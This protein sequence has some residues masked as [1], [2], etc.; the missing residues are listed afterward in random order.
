VID[1]LAHRRG[2]GT[3]ATVD[4]AAAD[5][6]AA[7]D[8]NHLWHPFT[9]MQ[10][11]CAADHE[12]LIIER[13]EDVWLWDQNG[14][15][16]ID[17]NSSIW[18]NIHGHSH[19]KLLAA[20][21]EQ[22]EKIAHSSFLGLT[23]EP[24]IRLAAGLAEKSPGGAL[25]RV[26]F[27]DDGSTAVECALK[28]AIQF[29]QMLGQPQRCEFLA[30]DKAYH[31]D[32][33]GAAT[34]GGIPAF[35]GRF[36]HL[37]FRV[38]HLSSAD[39]LP[40]VHE[41]VIDR[42]AGVVVE[43]L[44]QGAAGMRLWPSGMLAALRR[45][46]DFHDTFLIL[47]EVMTGFGRTGTL[48]ACEQENVAP[49][50]LALA[51]GLTGGVLPLAATL[52]TPRVF[53]A[54]LGRVEEMKTFYYGHSYSGNPLGCA[55]AL[56]SLRLFDEENTL[57]NV[58]QRSEEMSGLLCDLQQSHPRHVGEVR[59]LGLI[60]GIDIMED[61]AEQRHFPWH[62]MT[63]AK[64]CAA[65]RRFGLLTRPIRD[66]LVLMPP[67]SISSENLRMAVEAI[68]QALAAENL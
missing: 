21:R 24:A 39:Q 30:F 20:L 65:A 56:A 46:C 36:Q 63:G 41:E 33:L 28:M 54:F 32:T 22:A 64:V 15:R 68:H 18:T 52:T 67:L 4:R 14:R 25:S 48:F 37:G 16:Y 40:D 45:W 42:L 43:P 23:N 59:Q 34:L 58:R 12:P 51:K 49:D 13:G 31:G 53:S 62:Q 38:H 27:S 17:G 57:E 2:C 8:K 11:W 44:I 7:L 61:A 66:T 29:W 26:F 19:P 10:D 9:P 3:I 5:Q 50:F 60:A 35:H 55:V 1:C 47:D 6:L